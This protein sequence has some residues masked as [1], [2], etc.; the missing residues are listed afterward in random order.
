MTYITLQNTIDSNNPSPI[1]E[2]PLDGYMLYA[3]NAEV[4]SPCP[5]D[6]TRTNEG[7]CKVSTPTPDSLYSDKSDG[8]YLVG[9]DI[10]GE[11]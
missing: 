1:S 8:F 7:V 11:C 5:I 2:Y 6:K 10:A 3:A 4:L 9:V